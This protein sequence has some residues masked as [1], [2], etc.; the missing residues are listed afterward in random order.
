MVVHTS[1]EGVMFNLCGWGNGSVRSE[2]RVETS[3][4]YFK[5][6]EVLMATNSNFLKKIFVLL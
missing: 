1:M 5:L 4:M 2:A 6:S 3:Q